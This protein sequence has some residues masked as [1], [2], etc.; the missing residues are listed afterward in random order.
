MD[1]LENIINMICKTGGNI[2]YDLFSISNLM[3]EF[4][5]KGYAY[6]THIKGYKDGKE[7]RGRWWFTKRLD[8]LESIVQEFK[9]VEPFLVQKN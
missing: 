1:I 8:N 2:G 6:H 7:I 5:N 4:G 3:K 9:S